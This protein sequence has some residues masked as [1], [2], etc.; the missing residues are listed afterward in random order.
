[1]M[2]MVDEFMNAMNHHFPTCL[3]QFE[4]FSSDNAS[5]ILARYREKTLC[6]NDVRPPVALVR[7]SLA[8]PTVIVWCFLPSLQDIQGTGCVAL[9]GVLSALE[10]QGKPPEAL[11]DQRFLVAGAG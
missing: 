1:M 9:A 10:A 6:F 4:D 2:E 8:A 5:E 11:K 7:P 3:V